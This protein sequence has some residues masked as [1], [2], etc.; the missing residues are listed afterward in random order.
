MEGLASG[1]LCT[2]EGTGMVSEFESGFERY[3]LQEGPDLA[4]SAHYLGAEIRV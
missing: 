2:N 1:I 4:C 3:Y